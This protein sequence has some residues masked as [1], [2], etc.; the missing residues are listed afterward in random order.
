MK[1]VIVWLL[2]AVSDGAY[3]YG[4]VTPIMEYESK[5]ACQATAENRPQS[6]KRDFYLECLEITKEVKE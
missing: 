3:N 4:T 1:T 6:Y 2:I 5:V